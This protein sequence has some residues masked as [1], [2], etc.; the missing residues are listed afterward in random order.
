MKSDED[1][2]KCEWGKR[3]DVLGFSAF[4]LIEFPE[5]SQLVF[6]CDTKELL[7][8]VCSDSCQLVVVY[9]NELQQYRDDYEQSFY[10]EENRAIIDDFN[11]KVGYRV[12]NVTVDDEVYEDIIIYGEGNR[13]FRSYNSEDVKSGKQIV[14]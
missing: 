13:R 9:K 14:K 10:V 12:E 4:L 8:G 11:G 1:W 3:M 2:Q 6:D 7:G 5:D